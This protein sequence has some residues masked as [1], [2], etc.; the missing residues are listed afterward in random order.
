M[1]V[2]QPQTFKNLQVE[3]TGDLYRHFWIVVPYES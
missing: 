3:L 2:I 1:N